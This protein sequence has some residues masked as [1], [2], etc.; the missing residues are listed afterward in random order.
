MPI[1]AKRKFFPYSEYWI[2]LALV[3]LSFAT[4]A[5][6]QIDGRYT[7]TQ[8]DILPNMDFSEG[9]RYW[10]GPADGVRLSVSAPAT[11]ILSN[12]E[13]RQTLVTQILRTPQR[14]DSI[15]VALDIKLDGV[16]P[17]DAWWQRA[18]V[19]LES[20]DRARR[21]MLYWPSEVALLSGTVPWTRFDRVIPTA[22]QMSYMQLFILHGGRSGVLQV[23]NLRVD[24]MAET[25]W[26]RSVKMLLIVLWGGIG[27][28]CIAPL[29][30]R[31]RRSPLAYL[32]L[33][34]FAGMLAVSLTPQPLLSQSTVPIA[35]T[36]A[37][38]AAPAESDREARK[39]ADTTRKAKDGKQADTDAKTEP[40]Q[41]D[42][43]DT[44]SA[45][46]ASP[47]SLASDPMQYAAH[48]FGHVLLGV[49]AAML[50]RET[51]SWRLAGY[52]LF[53]ASTNELLQVFVVTRSA[54]FDDGLAN[55]AGAMVGLLTVVGM[56]TIRTRRAAA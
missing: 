18:G 24:A 27:L 52:L 14:F 38:V 35:R 6:F 5:I 17:G 46:G 7:V 26:F 48:F 36:I 15:R 3:F 13:R 1:K 51:A 39:P 2:P 20:R 25:A 11:L 34:A 50:F 29:I 55:M 21:R 28:Y 16:E 54:G 41:S 31:R 23:R 9:G 53:A 10:T 43:G 56:R 22:A 30:V 45:K 33:G 44:S 12:D 40:E 4:L 37:T 19:F 8:P 47:I 42:H 32:T 49:L